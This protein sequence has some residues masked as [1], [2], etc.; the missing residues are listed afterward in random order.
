MKVELEKII[1]IINLL[2][3]AEEKAPEYIKEDIEQSR[4][5]LYSVYKE[6]YKSIREIEDKCDYIVKHI[7]L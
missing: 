4:T 6:L 5:C 2:K 7:N 3:D 1:Q